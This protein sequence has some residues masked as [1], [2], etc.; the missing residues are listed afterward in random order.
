[1][2]AYLVQEEE[3]EERRCEMNRERRT[4]EKLILENGI[5]I[6]GFVASEMRATK[7]RFRARD[8]KVPK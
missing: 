4:F 3:K 6:R 5:G 2:V 8:G 7:E 1:M